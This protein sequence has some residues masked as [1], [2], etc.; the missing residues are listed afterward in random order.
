MKN[1]KGFTLIEVLI[2]ITLLAVAAVLLLQLT[3][4]FTFADMRSDTK[5]RALEIANEELAKQAE[6]LNKNNT[7]PPSNQ[8]IDGYTVYSMVTDLSSSPTYLVSM[9]K[10]SFVFVSAI[11]HYL[12]SSGT[13]VPK[14]L[15]VGVKW[16]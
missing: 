14:L 7:M 12:N 5:G 1:Q 13:V 15:V 9:D 3:G 2:S 6:E 16:K 4:F 10:N 11:V 8:L